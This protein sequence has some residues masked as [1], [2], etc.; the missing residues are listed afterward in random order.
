MA[1]TTAKKPK[2]AVKRPSPSPRSRPARPSA[3]DVPSSPS[4]PP[5]IS[6]DDPYAPS[7]WG[8]SLGTLGAEDIVCPSGQLALVKR[9]GVEGLITAGVLHDV[10]SLTGLVDSK[11]VR[12]V[13]G[14]PEV[15]VKSLMKDGEQLVKVLDVIDHVIVH[16]VIKPT[17]SPIWEQD[18]DGKETPLSPEKIEEGRKKGLIYVDQ[19]DITDKMFLFNYAVGGT[20]GLERFRQQSEQ[21]LDG[22]EVESDVEGDAE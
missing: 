12:R 6:A 14:K 1:G 21:L 16:I 18:E 7:V 4:L 22:M 15:D 2:K 9:P 20:R 11:H 19:V 5:G 17:I 3:L 13:K 10:D 8:Q